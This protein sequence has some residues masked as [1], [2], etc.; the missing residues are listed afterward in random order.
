MC[1]V[2]QVSRSGYYA[3]RTRQPSQ[4]EMAD[5]RFMQSIEE[6][7]VASR[8][9]YGYESIWRE[10]QRRNIACGKH[11]V[12][13]L[14]RQQG[15]VPKQVKRYKRTTKAN[16]DHQPAPNLLNQEFTAEQPNTKWVGDI[17]YIPTAVGWLYLAVVIDLFSRR[18]VGWAMGARMTSQLVCD[19]FNMAW[20]QR[21]PAAGLI[22]HSDRGSQYTSRA[23]QELLLRSDALSS[24]SGVGNCYDNA[25]A[26]AFFASL[27]LELIH[28]A[29]YQTRL[30]AELDIFYYIEGF[31]NRF[32]RHTTNDYLSPA[33]YEASHAQ[34]VV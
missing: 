24:M 9:T 13:R 11:R 12:R 33:Q 17:S 8:H 34:L 29:S 15:L 1:D 5:Q 32:R 27:K 31:Y 23:F 28:H 4:R 6:I 19:A 2:M 3:W 14:M 7:F 30:E 21:R 20:Q 18:V 22:F 16:P 26:E 25:V 10:L